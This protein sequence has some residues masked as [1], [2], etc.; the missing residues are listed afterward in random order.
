MA[1][2]SMVVRVAANLAE[3]KKN[4]AEGKDQIEAVR[5]G[6]TKLATSFQGDK[7]IQAAHN[8]TAAVNQVGGQTRP[9]R[10]CRIRK[11]MPAEFLP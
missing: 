9:A 10:S 1:Q 6:F 2:P 11:A 8:V 7:I 5:A 3:L 4:L